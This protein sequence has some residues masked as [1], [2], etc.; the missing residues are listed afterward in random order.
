MTANE[1]ATMETVAGLAGVS[2][3]LAAAANSIIRDYMSRNGAAPGE[4]ESA[5]G[6][7][8]RMWDACARQIG[9]ETTHRIADAHLVLFAATGTEAQVAEAYHAAQALM[10]W[11]A[12]RVR[13][14]AN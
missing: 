13:E 8:H 2:V 3:D 5:D 6:Y 10:R 9:A 4:R 11:F 14:R 12:S 7:Y 1:R